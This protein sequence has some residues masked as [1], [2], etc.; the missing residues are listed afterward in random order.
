MSSVLYPIGLTAKLRSP[1]INRVLADEFEDGSQSTRLLWPDKYFKRKFTLTHSNLT[2]EEY[3]WLRSFFTQRNGR[4]DS[5]WF[6]DNV[7]RRGNAL[8]RFAAELPEGRE[9]IVIDQMAVLMDEVA[10]IRMMPEWDEVETAAGSTLACYFDASREIYYSHLGTIYEDA[11]GLHDAAYGLYPA[12]VQDA[13][14]SGPSLVSGVTTAQWQ[15]YSFSGYK[16][17]KSASNVAAFAGT[18]PACT[19]FALVKQSAAPAVKQVLFAIGAT[20][21][22]HALGLAITTGGAIQ[23][24]VGGTESWVG[25]SAAISNNAWHSVAV[26][27]A[28][29][30]NVAK[31]YKDGVLIGNDTVTRFLTAGPLSIGAAPD[32]S[33]LCNSTGAVAG[34]AGHLMAFNAELTLAQVKALHNLVGYQQGLSTV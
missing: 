21:T 9:G 26:T 11:N 3:R 12:V 22:S 10:P 5:F 32:G 14:A 6:R 2:L 15:S 8:V 24:W 7:N 23:P 30:S 27:W 13:V 20:G 33:A 1:S 17:A 25:A 29:G 16:W 31:L 4:Y 28:S 19:L 18:Q 34:Y